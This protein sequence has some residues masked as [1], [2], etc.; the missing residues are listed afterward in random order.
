MQYDAIVIGGGAAGLIAAIVASRQ[1][2]KVLILE[3]NERLGKK[4]LI[5]A[6]DRLCRQIS[7]GNNARM[8]G[9][10][11]LLIDR[12]SEPD[13]DFGR[14]LALT[15]GVMWRPS[16]MGQ[17]GHQICAAGAQGHD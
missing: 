2:K 4:L 15:A 7:F 14:F 3:R 13:F 17:N 11:R 5:T 16:A 1:G 10:C 12:S 6:R 9:A 8:R